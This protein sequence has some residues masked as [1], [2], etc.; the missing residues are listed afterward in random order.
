MGNRLIET[1]KRG[2]TI[3]YGGIAMT[4]P[5]TH[6]HP[7]RE[8]TTHKIAATDETPEYEVQ[9]HEVTDE[10]RGR[11][12]V[13]GGVQDVGPGDVLVPTERGDV[14]HVLSKDAFA[15]LTGPR[16]SRFQ[17]RSRRDASSDTRR[18]DAARDE[19]F[20]DPSDH[21]AAEVRRRIDFLRSEDRH[22]EAERL[23]DAERNG[24]NRKSAIPPSDDED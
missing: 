24:K 1:W 6:D 12:Q 3:L 2:I 7:N 17:S 21:T 10:T 15:E 9:A 20:G 19:D 4:Q 8:F 22:D 16:K 13:P 18:A 11:V 5:I 23:A 14:Y